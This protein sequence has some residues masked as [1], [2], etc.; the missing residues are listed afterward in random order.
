MILIEKERNIENV[1]ILQYP[2][3]KITFY[4]KKDISDKSTASRSKPNCRCT[5]KK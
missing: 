5:V 2:Y 3:P 1:Y 4:F